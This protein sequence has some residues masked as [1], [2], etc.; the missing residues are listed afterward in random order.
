MAARYTRTVRWLLRRERRLR[1][2]LE[3]EL[4]VARDF[5]MQQ[6]ARIVELETELAWRGREGSATS[7]VK[8]EGPGSHGRAGL[9]VT[10]AVVGRA[11]RA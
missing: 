10:V 5:A 1:Q 8:R 7:N 2:Q 6:A 11:G 4:D 3:G 9:R